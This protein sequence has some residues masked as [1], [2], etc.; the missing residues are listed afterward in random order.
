M[1]NVAISELI[2]DG[3]VARTLEKY[4]VANDYTLNK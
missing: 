1:W 2:N 3:T 4:G